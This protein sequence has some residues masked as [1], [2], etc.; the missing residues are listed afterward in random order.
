MTRAFWQRVL[1]PGAD[2]VLSRWLARDA[3]V[4]PGRTLVLDVGAGDCPRLFVTGTRTVA[5]DVDR[6]RLL[7][8]RQRGA[9]VVQASA[10]RLPFA[11]E[12]FGATATVG[13]LHH[14]PDPAAAVAVTEMARVTARGGAVVV[15]DA[16]WPEPAWRRPL[17][18]LIRRLDR[19]RW[20]RREPELR[21][22]LSPGLSWRA[23]RVRYAATG[24][25]AL[26]AHAHRS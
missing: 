23:T 16:V 10:D 19:G 7:A 3:R 14:L 5:L 8:A 22:L 25:E 17:A 20:M 21:R 4:G 11:D 24:L 26:T 2:G 18:W 13:M 6:G 15:V 12:A 1:A 9:L